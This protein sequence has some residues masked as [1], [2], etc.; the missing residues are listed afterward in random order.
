MPEW[1]AESIESIVELS[2][3]GLYAQLAVMP[4]TFLLIRSFAGNVGVSR[5]GHPN[6]AL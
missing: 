6:D 1:C 3:G 4:R 5:A 2:V